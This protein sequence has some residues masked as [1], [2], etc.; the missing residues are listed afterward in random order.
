MGLETSLV[1]LHTMVVAAPW[2]VVVV[3]GVRRD[4]V[5]VA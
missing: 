4:M 2:C 3:A 5:K 1:S